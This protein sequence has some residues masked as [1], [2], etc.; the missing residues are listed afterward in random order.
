MPSNHTPGPWKMTQEDADPCWYMI[1]APGER[2]V[3]NVHIEP[4][5]TMDLANAHLILNSPELLAAC[6]E[7]FKAIIDLCEDPQKS[8]A[9]PAYR[10]MHKAIMKAKG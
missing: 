10:Q 1:V 2:V 7:G 3:A 5:N 9:G 8:V 4:G 6:E